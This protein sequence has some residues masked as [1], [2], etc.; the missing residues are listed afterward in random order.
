MKVRCWFSAGSTVL[1]TSFKE[2]FRL[3]DSWVNGWSNRWL[4]LGV[5]SIACLVLGL[6]FSA[7]LWATP[8]VSPAWAGLND[9]RYEGNIFPLYAGNGS[10]VPPRITLAE[11]RQRQLPAL[12]VFYIDDSA[13]CK[14]YSSVVSLLDSFYG[15]AAGFIPISVDAIPPQSSYDPTEAGYYYSGFV[16]QTVLLDQAGKV[17]LNQKG[18]IAFEQVDDAFRQVFDLLPRS[19]STELKRRPVNEV[20]TELVQ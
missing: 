20:N 2:V 13:D 12:L 1:S 15:R 3:K 8:G 17:V 7:A 16:P 11:A 6:I 10:L 19:E 9:D 18:A 4:K 14:K 5:R